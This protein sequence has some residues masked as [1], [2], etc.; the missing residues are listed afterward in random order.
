M[1]AVVAFLAAL[2]GSWTRINGAGLT[3]PDWPLCHGKLIPS[4]ADG[5]IWEWSHRLL[6]FLVSPL[7]LAV[8]VVAWRYRKAPTPIGF[9]MYLIAALFV[10]Q[11]L[12][13]AATVY[14][15]NSPISVVLHWGTAMAFVA[16]L[17]AISIFARVLCTSRPS[18]PDANRN[19]VALA[20]MLAGTTLIA[21]VTM[22]VGAYVSSSGA[23]LACLSL[24]G[25]AGKIV[26]YT[27]GQYVQML[28]RF[29]AAAALLCAAASFALA[30]VWRASSRVR[31]AV[32]LGSFFIFVQ[33]LLGL[34]NVTL[35]LPIDLREAHAAN[36]VF[37]FLSFV[38]ATTFASLDILPFRRPVA[39]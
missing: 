10:V 38:V 5:T 32:S 31:I 12:L 11:I 6:A 33:V 28:H 18:A 16:A 9:T 1:A 15:S 22:C 7:V 24:P 23:G 21:F 35:R 2:M 19:E 13:G 8:V 37:V 17:V 25:C 4:F 29:V 34:L 36:A 26:V 3:C 14:L 30:F 20:G 27:D 39:G